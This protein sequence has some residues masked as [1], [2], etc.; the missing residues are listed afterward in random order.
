VNSSHKAMARFLAAALVSLV[1]ALA[2]AATVTLTSNVTANGNVYHYDYTIANG[3]AD[4][5]FLI[6]I[7]VLANSSIVNL[8]APAGF[9]TAFDS[10]LG[11]VSFLE[12][13]A[14]FTA[15]PLGGFG[16]DSPNAPGTVTFAAS[17]LSEAGDIYTISGNAI[18][19]VPEPGFLWVFALLMAVALF[20]RSK[21]R[22]F[23]SNSAQHTSLEN[24]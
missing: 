22:A 19:P 5:A 10:G 24:I 3:T 15:T 23:F 20:G 4:D 2:N 14:M 1:P 17:L 9:N 12:D 6:D 18:A 13:T 21:L 7:P 11:L 8:A 16:F